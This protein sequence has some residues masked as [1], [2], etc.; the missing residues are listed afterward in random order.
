MNA[1]SRALTLTVIAIAAGSGAVI[2]RASSDTPARVAATPGGLSVAPSLIE[3]VAK[4]GAGGTIT[5]ANRSAK[6][7]DVTIRA[8]PWIQSRT[9]AAVPD[10]HHTLASVNLSEDSFT[11][12][13]QTQKAVVVSLRGTPAGGSL[14]GS[15]EVVGLP[16]GADKAHGV[17]V[18][19]RLISVLRMDPA[20]PVHSFK[21]AAAKVVGS[22]SARTIVLPVQNTGNTADLLTGD[23]RLS[24]P[25]G[26]RS[27]ALAAVRILPGRIVQL[28]LAKLKA[29]PSGSYTATVQLKQAK[30][31]VAT[32]TKKV[33]VSR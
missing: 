9:G 26:T 7:V 15:L 8:R 14:Y 18:G 23:V 4:A 10:R 24:G 20:T 1:R 16:P 25:L 11:L 28:A 29:L 2:A 6:A 27:S 19:Y 3:Q 21:A 32:V 13:P 5:V 22:G 31:T 12:P 33:R 17:I 30:R